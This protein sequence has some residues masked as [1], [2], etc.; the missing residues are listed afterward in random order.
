[1]NFQGEG[2]SQRPMNFQGKPTFTQAQG[3][4]FPEENDLSR[5]RS[6]FSIAHHDT[7]AMSHFHQTVR[8][9]INMHRPLP[10]TVKRLLQDLLQN[11]YNYTL[12][13]KNKSVTSHLRNRPCRPAILSHR[14]ICLLS[15]GG[16]L[17]GKIRWIADHGIE[18]SE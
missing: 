10:E 8:R 4:P 7:A 3:K 14:E 1:M 2:T 16:E 18:I 15:S 17:F 6:L 12:F 9:Q 11:H 5:C 13:C